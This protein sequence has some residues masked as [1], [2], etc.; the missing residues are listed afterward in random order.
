ML[1]SE[2]KKLSLDP[3]ICTYK[4]KVFYTEFLSISLKGHSEILIHVS[5]YGMQEMTKGFIIQFNC[6]QEPLEA[7]DQSLRFSAAMHLIR[8]RN[9]HV[10]VC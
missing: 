9:L 1:L 2:R 6:E 5:I 10:G 7:E 4:V 3:F 8:E